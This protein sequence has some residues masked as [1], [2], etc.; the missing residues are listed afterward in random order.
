MFINSLILAEIRLNYRMVP[1]AKYLII[2][3]HY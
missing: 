1:G 2:M 3:L